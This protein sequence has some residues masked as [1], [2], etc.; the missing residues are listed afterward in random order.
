M[1][2][3]YA[4]GVLKKDHHDRLVADLASF[5]KDAGI[6]P[7]WIWTALADTCGPKEVA[8]VRQFN[9][10]RA[11]GLIQGL[12]FVRKLDDVPVAPR[13]AALAGALVR[14][15]VRARVM[16]VGTVLDLCAHSEPPDATCLLIPNFFLPKSEGGTIATWQITALYDLLTHRAAMG[17]QTV[18]FAANLAALG[19]EYGSAFSALVRDSYKVVE[20]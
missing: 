10:H 19:K 4:T 5:A 15:F 13:M 17:Q 9:R 11:E 1:T 8:Y 12:C 2:D 14:N 16:T 3:P 20:L 6:Q 18:I 7:R